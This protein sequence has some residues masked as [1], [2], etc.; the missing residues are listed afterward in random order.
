MTAEDRSESQ[1]VLISLVLKPRDVNTNPRVLNVFF[2]HF[3]SPPSDKR[4]IPRSF[5]EVC[6]H[7]E[8]GDTG[9]LVM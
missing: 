6:V 1:C 2:Y 9:N 7:L 4:Q 5:S 8:V 3:P